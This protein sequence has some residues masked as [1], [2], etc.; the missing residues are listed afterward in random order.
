MLPVLKAPEIS[1]ENLSFSYPSAPDHV[2]LKDLSVFFTSGSLNIVL[3]KSGCGKSTLMRLIAGLYLPSSGH[4]AIDGQIPFKP[5]I[6]RSLIFQRSQLFPW[7][8]VERNIRF[9]LKRRAPEQIKEKTRERAMMLLQM[10]GLARYAGRYPFQLSGGMIQRAAFAMT[11]AQGAS[12]WLMDEPFSSLDPDAREDLYELFLDI[13]DQ[14]RSGKTI[15]VVTH[16]IEEALQLGQTISYLDEGKITS[17]FDIRGLS[18]DEKNEMNRQIYELF[19]GK[20]G[21]ATV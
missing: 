15:I 14:G 18:D 6:D 2:V 7:M 13:W 3:G 1:V 11:L 5:S 19:T 10:V 17:A 9:V 20:A 4:I 8:T 21:H 16:D 12:L